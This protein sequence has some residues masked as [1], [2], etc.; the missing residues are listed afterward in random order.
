[1]LDKFLHDCKRVLQV[2]HKPDKD[3]YLDVVKITGIGVLIVGTIG[4]I[5]Y[6]FG[7][8]FV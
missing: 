2:A 1:M 3:E 8:L 6:F 7:N 4:F 5:I